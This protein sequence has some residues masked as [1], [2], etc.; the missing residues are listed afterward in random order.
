MKIFGER[1]RELRLEKG[2]TTRELGSALNVTNVTISRWENNINDIKAE[3]LV[4]VANYFKVSIDYLLGL[5]N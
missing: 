3:E 4:K 2:L 5:E 1:L